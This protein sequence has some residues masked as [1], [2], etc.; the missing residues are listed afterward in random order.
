[1]SHHTFTVFC[2]GQFRHLK[3][4]WHM[5][6]SLEKTIPVP[7]SLI[8]PLKWQMNENNVLCGQPPKPLQHALQLF[9]DES[10]EGWSPHLGDCMQKKSLWSKPESKPHINFLEQKAVLLALSKHKY[11]CLGPD[12]SGG[13]GQDKSCVVQQQDAIWLFLCPSLETVSWCKFRQIVLRARHMPG[14]LNVIDDKLS[15]H[16]QVIQIEW[17]LLRELFGHLCLRWHTLQMDLFIST[18]K[19]KLPKFISQ[20]K[21]DPALNK[22]GLHM[23]PH[24]S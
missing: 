8:F 24:K 19:N 6:E 18:F 13:N 21:G 15:R 3:N 11:L 14:H 16:K 10:N 5:L 9:T 12:H 4:H 23:K 17:S 1:M 20:V 7:R 2:L 22:E